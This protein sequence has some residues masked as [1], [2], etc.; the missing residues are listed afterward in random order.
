MTDG[1]DKADDAAAP[2]GLTGDW[3]GLRTSLRDAGLELG[4]TY[5][6]EGLGNPAG[7]V[8]RG[9]IYEGRLEMSLDIDL[10]KA[11]GWDGAL[12]H[13]NA[14]QIHGRGL[15]AKDLG[16][17]FLVASS[18]EALRSSRLFDLWFQQELFDRRVS[19]RAGQIAADDEFFIS[20]YGATFVNST[21]GWPGILAA[22]LP[23]GGPAYP[24][25]TPGFRIK[26]Q[27]AKSLT[28][29]AALFDGDPA[30]PG[31]GDPQA[32]DRSG[33]NF[34][35]S[36]AP[37]TIGEL[38]YAVKPDKSDDRLPATYKLGAWYHAGR[39]DDVRF[40]NTSRSLA[41]PASNGI[42][43]THRGN[44]G[45]YVVLDQMIWR[46]PDTEDEGLGAF[47]R[48]S[49][50]PSNRNVIDFYADGGLTFKGIVPSRA[51]D[52]LGLGI[53]FARVSSAARNLD[54]DTNAF[55]GSDAPRRAFEAALELTY[56]AQVTPWWSIQ[57]DLQFI[58]HPAGN[59]AN[60]ASASGTE[61]IPNA[62]IIGLR[63]TIKF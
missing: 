40:D 33:T 12:I 50:S 39:F 2:D 56:K 45:G 14:Y 37:F 30:G 59:A 27:P 62:F 10:A 46:R 35:T 22:D 26:L 15:S 13:A 7:G 41:D 4:V 23:S 51:D 9:A 29:S 11:I 3:G 8:K 57:P 54:S 63:S 38:A 6:G 42:A 58:I 20:D 34:R 18:I 36:D 28:L 47:L 1:P 55:T 32:R 19:V 5:I 61:P 44:Y 49:G 25:A 53:A 52:I 16:N 21:F 17:N 48:L 43:A 60:P 31:Q 24:L